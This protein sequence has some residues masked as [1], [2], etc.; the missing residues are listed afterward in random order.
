MADK[1]ENCRFWQRLRPGQVLEWDALPWSDE[2][3]DKVEAGECQRLP[4]TIIG[5]ILNDSRNLPLYASKNLHIPTFGM[6]K[7]ASRFPVT[8]DCDWCGEWKERDELTGK[9]P[10]HAAE[11]G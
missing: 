4:P 1:C 2:V 8:F 10:T 3:D 7:F 6:I 11:E 9:E 5:T